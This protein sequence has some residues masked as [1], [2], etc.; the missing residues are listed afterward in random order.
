MP[1]VLVSEVGFRDQSVVLA[2]LTLMLPSTLVLVMV[3]VPALGEE[4]YPVR[5]THVKVMASYATWR[6]TKANGEYDVKTFDVKARPI[7]PIEGLRPGMTAI[8]ID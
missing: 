2:R 7:S 1:P 5:I 3:K 8:I 4:T 6:A